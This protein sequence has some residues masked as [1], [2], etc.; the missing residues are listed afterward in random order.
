MCFV[1][2][3][4]GIGRR[5]QESARPRLYAPYPAELGGLARVEEAVGRLV[6]ECTRS[7]FPTRFAVCKLRA[8]SGPVLLISC[9]AP[10]RIRPEHSCFGRRAAAMPATRVSLTRQRCWET[11]LGHSR[12]FHVF[13]TRPQPRS[14]RLPGAA[15]L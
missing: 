10:S 2:A 6:I 3:G 14:L 8:N 12:M 11:A 1:R 15:G 7:D 9:V 5:A 4:A 13:E